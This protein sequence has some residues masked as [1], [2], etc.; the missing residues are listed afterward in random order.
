M[1][2]CMLIPGWIFGQHLGKRPF[3]AMPE[4]WFWGTLNAYT[5]SCPGF[6]WW[7]RDI[8]QVFLTDAQGG[9]L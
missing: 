9:A 1:L 2:S 7:L 8:E 6:T 4:P 5:P 3:L